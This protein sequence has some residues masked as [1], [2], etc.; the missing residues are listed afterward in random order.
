MRAAG[1]SDRHGRQHGR[2]I[3]H[4]PRAAEQIA[5]EGRAAVTGEEG[6]LFRL[7]HA[8]GHHAQLKTGRQR[9]DGARDGRAVGIDQHLVDEGLV[10]LQLVQRQLL[11]IAE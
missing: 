2:Q 4:R 10:D 8:L 11:Q 1:I 9:Q 6:H 3:K 5:L 7:F